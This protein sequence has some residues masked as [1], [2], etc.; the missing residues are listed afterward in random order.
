[1]Q[2][3]EFMVVRDPTENVTKP[4]DGG[5]WVIHKQIRRKPTPDSDVTLISSYYVIGENIYM[6]PS[7]G[8]ILEARLVGSPPTPMLL[9]IW[10][11]LMVFC[12]FQLCSL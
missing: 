12:S 11:S 9:N 3:L 5:I 4:D 8:R 7:L 6:A 1:M 10:R 2:G